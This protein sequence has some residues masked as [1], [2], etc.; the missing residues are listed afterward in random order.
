[1]MDFDADMTDAGV[2]EIERRTDA[3]MRVTNR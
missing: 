2:L 3:G 1:V